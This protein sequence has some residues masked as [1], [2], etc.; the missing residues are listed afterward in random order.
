MWDPEH[1]RWRIAKRPGAELFLFY[2]AQMF[3]LIVFSSLPQHEGD[4]LVKKLDPFGCISHSLFRFATTHTSNGT[5]VKDLSKINRNL[6]K[7]IV[8]GH[9]KAGFSGQPENFIQMREWNGNAKDRALEESI[10]YLEMLAFSR[11]EDLR[12]A[13]KYQAGKVFPD[14][15]EAEQAKTFNEARQQNLEMISKR[16][17]NFFFRLIGLSK[18]ASSLQKELPTYQNKKDERIDL[19]RREFAHLRD[20]MMKQMQAEMEKEKAFYKEHKMALWDLF[21]KGP[22]APKPETSS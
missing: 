18:S 19:R 15:F 2:A 11:M 3:E 5:Y 6:Q 14:D 20:L 10:D 17:N 8:L 4:A 12:P 21:S 16:N 13:I 9:D 7:V 22:P 1:S